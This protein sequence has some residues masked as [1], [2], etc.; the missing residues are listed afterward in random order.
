[1]EMN[2][3]SSRIHPLIAG[4]AVSVMLVSLSGVA[5]ITGL[6]PSSHGTVAAPAVTAAL[7]T[8]VTDN[9]PAASPAKTSVQYAAPAPVVHHQ[10]VVHHPVATRTQPVIHADAGTVRQPS[11]A[12]VYQ[13]PAPAAEN[14]PVG[15]GV[16]AVI[17]GLL[18]NQ[19]GGGNGRTL[20]PI[21]GAVSGGYI[22][23]EVAKRNR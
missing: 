22:G 6:L 9:L 12:P 4:A 7:V 20:A 19:V 18:G 11:A 2:Q 15:I 13:Q 3:S 10:H 1:M 5:A 21:A 14:S 23:N 17:G 16:G 8:P